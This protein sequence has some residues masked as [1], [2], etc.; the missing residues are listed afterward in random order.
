MYQTPMTK[1]SAL[2]FTGDPIKGKGTRPLRQKPVMY[3]RKHRDQ[4]GNP[5]FSNVHN[6]DSD[7]QTVVPECIKQV[8]KSE[9]LPTTSTTPPH[10]KLGGGSKED[11]GTMK[12]GTKTFNVSGHSHVQRS[13]D[14]KTHSVPGHIGK[15]MGANEHQTC[16]TPGRIG[17]QMRDHR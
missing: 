14:R 5:K 12:F 2:Q 1:L 11:F 8:T 4:L 9:P 15:P 3:W 17:N 10:D 16:S 7:R 6:S 13:N